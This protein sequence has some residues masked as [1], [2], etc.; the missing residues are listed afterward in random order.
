MACVA[1]GIL[2]F[3]QF[4]WAP[5]VE[6]RTEARQNAAMRASVSILAES[7]APHMLRREY[8]A[9]QENLDALMARHPDWVAIAVFNADDRRIYSRASPALK[10]EDGGSIAPPRPSCSTMMSW[11]GSPFLST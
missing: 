1:V 10:Q 5:L 7:V 11:A 2:A 6:A 3:I 4:Y 9:I 8:A